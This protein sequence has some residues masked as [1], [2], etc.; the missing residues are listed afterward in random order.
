MRKVI[1]LVTMLLLGLHTI[2]YSQTHS[3]KSKKTKPMSTSESTLNDRQT[4]F[5]SRLNYDMTQPLSDD[6]ASAFRYAA[7][8]ADGHQNTSNVL[9]RM[10]EGL[11]NGSNLPALVH[12]AKI[13]YGG[14]AALALNGVFPS[15]N[16]EECNHLATI[17]EAELSGLAKKYAQFIEGCEK[18]NPEY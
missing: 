5:I 7:Y 9:N 6:A 15:L 3:S 11:K 2:G 10:A 18:E 16:F 14:R 17:S 1:L 4:D 12:Y 8:Q 13:A